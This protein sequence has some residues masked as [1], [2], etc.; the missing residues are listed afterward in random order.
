MKFGTAHIM[1]IYY[2]QLIIG[3]ELNTQ[4]ITQKKSLNHTLA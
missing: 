1:E 4:K 2:H 3:L